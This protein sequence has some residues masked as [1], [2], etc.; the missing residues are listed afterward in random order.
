LRRAKKLP[1]LDFGRYILPMSSRWQ[2]LPYFAGARPPIAVARDAD[3]ERRPE[4][5]L[6]QVVGDLKEYE[7]SAP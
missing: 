2:S 7:S 3:F 1:E 4:K 6:A 5:G